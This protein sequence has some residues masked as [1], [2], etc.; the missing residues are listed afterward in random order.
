M[1]PNEESKKQGGIVNYVIL[2][3]V[4]IRKAKDGENVTSV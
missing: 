3:S 2:L 1:P 4:L